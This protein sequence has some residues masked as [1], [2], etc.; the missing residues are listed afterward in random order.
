L[1]KR[2]DVSEQ[3]PADDYGEEDEYDQEEVDEIEAYN[4]GYLDQLES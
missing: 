1:E 3:E 2:H 4:N